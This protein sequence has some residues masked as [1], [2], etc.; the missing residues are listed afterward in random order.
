LPLIALAALAPWSS[1]R[2]SWPPTALV[3]ASLAV[4][5]TARQEVLE[6]V[7]TMAW[8]DR[9]FVPVLPCLAAAAAASL[10]GFWRRFATSPPRRAAVALSAAMVFVWQLANPAAN[11]ASLLVRTRG[12]PEAVAARGAPSA[13]FL[14]A[15][16]G[17]GG[18]IIAGDVGRVGYVFTGRVLDLYGL[19][20]YSRTL[21]YDGALEPYLDSLLA[22]E[23]DAIQLCFDAVN[24]D[25]PRPCQ[26]AE[27]A[28]TD[29][30][31]FATHYVEDAEFGRDAA[32]RAYHVIYRRGNEGAAN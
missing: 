3:G 24:H 17:A 26:A 7:S 23:P 31:A 25:P 20:S 15:K 29:R 6:G 11:P 13:A 2:R 12:Y 19:A 1:G 9:Y 22:R 16:Y 28:L 27:R 18:T 10:S 30:P 8:L 21:E 14:E 5:A 32:P 4:F